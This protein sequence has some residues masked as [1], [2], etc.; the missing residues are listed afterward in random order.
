MRDVSW[1]RMCSGTINESSCL[2]VPKWR[3]ETDDF[4]IK[5]HREKS[6]KSLKMWIKSNVLTWIVLESK[7]KLMF[8][9]AFRHFWLSKTTSI[10]RRWLTKLNILDQ[11]LHLI[12]KSNQTFYG[13]RASHTA[14]TH[15]S[16]TNY[17][18]IIVSARS[19]RL[20]RNSS[21][22]RTWTVSDCK[23]M[24][25]EGGLCVILS[26]KRL[27]KSSDAQCALFMSRRA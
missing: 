13:L 18:L 5:R 1:T 27:K 4:F 3:Q 20:M 8:V 23:W 24:C 11:F 12:S 15:E 17:A 2:N 10:M 26:F 6:I 7:F 14:K 9:T 16:H 21:V 22:D 25:V 19:V